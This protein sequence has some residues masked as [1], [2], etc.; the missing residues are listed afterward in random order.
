VLN[1]QELDIFFA[2]HFHHRAFRQEVGEDYTGAHE[3]EILTRYLNNEPPPSS[4]FENP[5]LDELRADD[6]AGKRWQ[7]VHVVRQRPLSAYLRC[8]FEWGYQANVRSG[9]QV[10]IL[11]LTEQPPSPGFIDEEFWTLDEE[12]GLR[13]LYTDGAFIGAEPIKD[14]T[15][16]L[17]YRDMVWQSAV[18]L[19]RYW[20][21]HPQYHRTQAA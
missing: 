4:L 16:Y 5:F 11:D 20:Q 7:W 1:A 8:A 2:K 19:N 10:K 6:R 13:M 12:A 18:P 14:V 21:T 9:A 15:R 17:A 3:Q